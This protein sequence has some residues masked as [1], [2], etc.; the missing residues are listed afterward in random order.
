[1]NGGT[2]R[3]TW[4][5]RAT[6]AGVGLALGLFAI[7]PTIAAPSKEAGDV[8][9][10]QQTHL[11]GANEGGSQ[12]TTPSGLGEGDDDLRLDP[13][14]DSRG[15]SILECLGTVSHASIDNNF[16]R[17]KEQARELCGSATHVR[18]VIR[19]DTAPCEGT[20]GIPDP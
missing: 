9:G 5:R 11:I 6:A 19:R 15:K 2:M 1:M 14:S 20:A 12:P 8:D 16:I 3:G 13:S 4:R 18:K 17:L 10:R 7:V